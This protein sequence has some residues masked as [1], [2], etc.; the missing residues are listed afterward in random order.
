MRRA[1]RMPGPSPRTVDA[2]EILLSLQ[3]ASAKAEVAKEHEAVVVGWTKL[4][5]MRL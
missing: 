4:P 3:R 1:I 5:Q 2:A